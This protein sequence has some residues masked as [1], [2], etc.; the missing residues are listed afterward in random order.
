MVLFGFCYF[1]KGELVKATLPPGEPASSCLL[2]QI[3]ETTQ[4]LSGGALQATPHAVRST[5][6]EGERDE[7]HRHRQDRSS[8]DSGRNTE[9]GT[10]TETK[11]ER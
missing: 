2:F 6:Q 10:E 9:A 3:G 5:S 8:I 1:K 4:A 7:R 11:A